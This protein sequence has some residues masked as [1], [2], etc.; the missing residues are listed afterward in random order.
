MC[1][2]ALVGG[3][4]WR[5]IARGVDERKERAVGRVRTDRVLE[6]VAHIASAHASETLAVR[7]ARLAAQRCAHVGSGCGGEDRT[8]DG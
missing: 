4:N 8:H 6:L 1:L 3:A 7:A 5:R 2:H